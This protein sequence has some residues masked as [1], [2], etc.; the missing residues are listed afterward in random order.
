M[1]TAAEHSEWVR[2][3]SARIQ[4]EGAAIT[5]EYVQHITDKFRNEIGG[6]YAYVAACIE[7]DHR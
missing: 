7:S 4:S 2:A 6:V 1:K 5:P 3:E